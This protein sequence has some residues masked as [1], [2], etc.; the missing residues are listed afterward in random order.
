MPHLYEL[1][2]SIN[3]AIGPD[4]FD[5]DTGEVKPEAMAALDALNLDFDHKTE[6]VIAYIK[7]VE[8]DA[9]AFKDALDELK[10]KQAAR[11]NLAERL[12]TYLFD[13]LQ[14]I[15][16]EK[17]GGSIFTAAIQLG[18]PALNVTDPNAIPANFY[19]PQPPALDKDAVKTALKGG[20]TV[21]GAEIVRNKFLRIR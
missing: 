6:A 3:A 13:Q 12:R 14:R 11:T 4:G 7:G 5:P 21:P 20:A 10:K 1:A 19:I 17:A 15:G 2:N 18:P 9:D 8:A 16:R